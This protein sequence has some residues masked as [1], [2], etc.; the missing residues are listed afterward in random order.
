MNVPTQEE[1]SIHEAGHVV[2]ARVLRFEVEY[3][4]IQPNE[5]AYGRTL[6]E[7][8]SM[9]LGCPFEPNSLEISDDLKLSIKRHDLQRGKLGQ[10]RLRKYIAIEIAGHVSTNIRNDGNRDFEVPCYPDSQDDEIA[11]ALAL[12]ELLTNGREDYRKIVQWT[13]DV[14]KQHRGAVTK[15]AR[16][17]MEKTTI[18]GSDINIEITQ[19]EVDEVFPWTW[20]T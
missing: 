3:V 6:I 13:T 16:E 12:S 4:T 20:E 19:R 1:I 9:S 7:K 10:R 14:I 17:L 5:S 11:C 2:V 15:L 18:K 8:L